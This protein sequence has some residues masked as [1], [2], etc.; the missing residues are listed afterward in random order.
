MCGISG[1]LSNSDIRSLPYIKNFNKILNHRGPDGNGIWYSENH[2]ACF[3]HTRLAIQDLSKNGHQPMISKS[4][5][6]RTDCKLLRL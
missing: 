4:K 5:L 1:I 2:D 3:F 6:F